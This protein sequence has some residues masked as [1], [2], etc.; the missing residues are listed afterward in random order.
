VHE[1]IVV[2]LR[3]EDEVELVGVLP[4]NANGKADRRALTDRL[5]AGGR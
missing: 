4:L 5:L 1:A 3:H 2:A